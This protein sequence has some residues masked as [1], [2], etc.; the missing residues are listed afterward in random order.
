M[1][2][3]RGGGEDIL[4][5]ESRF[6]VSVCLPSHRLLVR[7]RI[8]VA[9]GVGHRFGPPDEIGLGRVGRTGNCFLSFGCLSQG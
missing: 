1:D 3:E 7:P 4:Y 2:A 8:S 5:S 9:W 6:I